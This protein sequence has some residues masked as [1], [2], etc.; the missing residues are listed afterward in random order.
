MR[1]SELLAPLLLVGF[2]FAWVYGVG[3]ASTRIMQSYHG[4]HHAAY[5]VQIANGIVPPTNPSSAE[6]PANFYWAWHAGLAFGV[7]WMGVTPFEMSLAS[8]ALGLAAFLCGFWLAAGAFTRNGGLRLAACAIPLFILNPLGLL[9]FAVRL[10]GVG[11]PELFSGTYGHDGLAAHLLGIARHHSALGLA[12]LSLANLFPRL[13]LLDDF[14]LSER[15]GHLINKFLNFN[16]FPFALGVF[17]LAQD[18]FVNQR[19]R[20][21]FRCV[22][23][24]AA[25]FTMAVTSPL[26]VI[27]FGL[28]VFAGLIVEGPSE[29]RA[30]RKTGFVGRRHS[31]WLFVAPVLSCALGVL[32]A[33]PHLLPIIAAYDGEA[34]VLAPGMGLWRHAVALGWALVPGI[35][36]L[37]FATRL[38]RDLDST[39]RVHAL[40]L[41]FYVVAAILLVAP[42]RDPNEY[43]FVLL[44]AYPSGLLV[45]GLLN[46][47]ARRS[48]SLG[49]PMRSP[50]PLAVLFAAG[51]GLGVAAVA[52]LYL[53]SPWADEES[54]R[55]EGRTTRLAASGDALTRDLDEAYAWLRRE[56]PVEAYVFERPTSKD[57]SL[58]PGLAERRVVAQL[59]SPFTRAVSHHEALLD[60]NRALLDDL[61]RCVLSPES[62]SAL[63]AQPIDWP[64]TEYAIVSKRAGRRACKAIPGA[65]QVYAND[66]VAIFR[67]P[68]LGRPGRT[69]R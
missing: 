58:L 8:N 12:D 62:L 55:L 45:L 39:A 19:G 63:R 33:L 30:L 4:L 22:A 1:I 46:A 16:S 53:A 40:S 31:L 44:S 56:T 3:G 5:V 24:A 48:G 11:L 23:L 14:V 6:M 52:L 13:G 17:A 60:A 21:R 65:P 41:S 69:S 18:G 26:V 15:A 36:L 47:W 42:V 51:G 9:Q 67:L 49:A 37:G 10:L 66:H 29:L 54:L 59:A 25:C 35:A 2:A 27:G 61:A 20:L 32:L 28:S 43:K 34:R 38:G 50:V 7:R 57:R 68:A 64:G